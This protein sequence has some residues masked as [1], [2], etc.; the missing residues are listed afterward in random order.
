MAPE[1]NEGKQD[2]ELEETEDA[3]EPETDDKVEPA[4]PRKRRWGLWLFVLFLVLVLAVVGVGW[5]ASYLRDEV[6]GLKAQLGEAEQTAGSLATAATAVASELM[7]L[8]EESV[9]VAKLRQGSGN[10]E[11]AVGALHRAKAFAEMARRLTPTRRPA[12]LGDIE[13]QIAEVEKA[14]VGA[15]E[16]ETSEEQADKEAEGGSGEPAEPAEASAE[17]SAEPQSTTGG[18][19][20]AGSP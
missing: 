3:A 9:L 5:Y 14:L 19:P 10:P 16:P 4:A 1:A 6:A 12:K 7:P 13:Q 2:D 20:E 8:A 18:E 17:E 11:E 15:G